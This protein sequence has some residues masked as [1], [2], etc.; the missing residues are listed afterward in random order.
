M[1]PPPALNRKGM[2]VEAS[3]A[4]ARYDDILERKI[5]VVVIDKKR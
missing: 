5:K 1:S 4:G 3:S 2:L